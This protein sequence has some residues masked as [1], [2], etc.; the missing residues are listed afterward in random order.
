MR[1]NLESSERTLS[2][3]LFFEKEFARK[4]DCQYCF[5]RK[6]SFNRS[7]KIVKSNTVSKYNISTNFKLSTL[8]HHY[9][10]YDIQGQ[11]QE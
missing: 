1:Q 2:A 10:L 6:N 8:A 5:L 9:K 4:R 3:H 11:T 7:A